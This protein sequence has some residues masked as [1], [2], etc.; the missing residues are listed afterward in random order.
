MTSLATL[1]ALPSGSPM[2]LALKVN[3]T[4]RTTNNQ[5]LLSLSTTCGTYYTIWLLKESLDHKSHIKLHLSITC[6]GQVTGTKVN[7]D[8]QTINL[9]K[10]SRCKPLTLS[11]TEPHPLQIWNQNWIFHNQLNHNMLGDQTLWY[12]STKINPLSTQIHL[13]KFLQLLLT[14]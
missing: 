6:M 14:P 5:L 13:M 10:F 12:P 1:K 3:I 7:Q 11:H 8:I 4:Q 9:H 2:K